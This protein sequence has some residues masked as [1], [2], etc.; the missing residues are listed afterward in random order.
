MGT[1]HTA[2]DLFTYHVT[3][4]GPSVMSNA[5]ELA[6]IMDG[7]FGNVCGNQLSTYSQAHNGAALAADAQTQTDRSLRNV[8]PSKPLLTCTLEE[9][10]TEDTNNK[11]DEADQKPHRAHLR[12]HVRDRLEVRS[13]T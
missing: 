7:D 1:E 9:L 8:T 6:E 12:Q 2:E 10:Q 13:E 3:D 4:S 11:E 5:E